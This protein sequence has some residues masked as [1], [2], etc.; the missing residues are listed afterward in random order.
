MLLAGAAFSGLVMADCGSRT[1]KGGIQW[2]A[3]RGVS[4][5][6]KES[7]NNWYNVYRSNQVVGDG[8]DFEELSSLKVK[9]IRLDSYKTCTH[10][11]YCYSNFDL[12]NE[13]Y[14]YCIIKD[15]NNNNKQLWS[16]KKKLALEG[17]GSCSDGYSYPRWYDTV[18]W[19]ITH[20]NN[21]G[22]KAGRY[23][24][25]F[26]FLL[27]G[28]G[29]SG[30]SCS[31]SQ[32]YGKKDD[33]NNF[34]AYFVI[35]GMSGANSLS[36]ETVNKDG[37]PTQ[38][39][40]AYKFYAY[41][42]TS[43]T[44]TISSDAGS[45][46]SLSKASRTT[47]S[48][49]SI[50]ATTYASSLTVYYSAASEG[51]HTATLTISG[52]DKLGNPQSI[53][54]ALNGSTSD[55]YTTKVL[56]EKDAVVEVGP[57]ATLYG[58][59]KHTGCQTDIKTYGFYYKKKTGGAIPTEEEIKAGSHVDITGPALTVNNC[60]FS[61]KILSGLEANSDY[62]YLAYVK[63]DG[64]VTTYSPYSSVGH[65][66][67]A[68]ACKLPKGDVINYYVD[69]SLEED[70]P[71]ELRFKSIDN[72][73]D[74]LRS[75]TSS[76]YDWWD[77]T[78]KTLKVNVILNIYDGNYGTSGLLIDLKNIN[79][80]SAAS[81]PATK[82]LTVQGV[83]GKPTLYGLDLS[84]SR[85]ITVK[86]VRIERSTSG[87]GLT[88]SCVI[89]GYPDPMNS[90]SV[91]DLPE[92]NLEFIDTDIDATAFTCIHG[93]GVNGLYM[94]NCNLKANRTGD[95]EDNDR[96]WGASI[97][98]MNCK[99]ISLL[100]NNFRGSHANNIFFQNSRNALIMNNVFWNDNEITYSASANVDSPSFIR[101]VNFGANDT[102]HDITN[103]GIYY[104]TFYLAESSA[105]NE[106]LKKFDYLI[107]SGPAQIKD[108]GNNFYSARYIVSSIHFQYNN[109]YSYSTRI[110]GKSSDPFHSLDVDLYFKNNN[111]WA[112]NDDADYSF[113][114][115]EKKNVDMSLG[116]PM[117]CV[118][119]PYNP[120]D[121]IIKG[122]LL[123]YGQ[124]ITSDVSG[125][126]AEAVYDDRPHLGARPASGSGW[127]YGAYQQTLP[128]DTPIE[129]IV[130]NGA[131]NTDW[132]NRNN[133][134]KAD[135]TSVNC[136]DKLSENLKVLIPEPEN[137][138]YRPKSEEKITNY[139]TIQA[140]SA[141]STEEEV[142]AGLGTE[143]TP[144]EYA[145]SIELEYGALL[146]GIENLRDPADKSNY[147]YFEATNHNVVPKKTWRLVGTVMRPFADES[148]LPGDSATTLMKADNY[149]KNFEPHVYM[150]QMNS[151]ASGFNMD[152][153]FT[154][155]NTLVPSDECFAVF[156]ANQYGPRKLIAE[157]YYGAD[158]AYLGE[159]A[160][161]F[162]FRGH[163]A[164]DYRTG[165]PSYTFSVK[166]KW[167]YVNNSY[168][169]NL[170]VSEF[171]T[172]N[173]VVKL[174]NGTSF[175]DYNPLSEEEIRPQC[176]FI[177]KNT[178]ASPVVIALDGDS[179]TTNS[180]KYKGANA[181]TGLSLTAVNTA[182]DKGSSIGA[183]QDYKNIT[184]MENS[185]DNEVCELY[186]NGRDDRYSTISFQNADTVIS[187]GI[188]NKLVN[189]YMSV[190][191]TLENYQGLESV[192]LEDRGVEPVVR[193]DL[194]DGE[195]PYIQRLQPGYIDGRFF[196]II[197]SGTE[198]DQPTSVEEVESANADSQ[199]S[200]TSDEGIVTV[201]SSQNVLLTGAYITDMSGRTSYVE[202]KNAHYN[203][204]NIVGSAG[205]YIVN[206]IGDTMSKSEK[207]IVK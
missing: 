18:E 108:D 58:Y 124:R 70:D 29:C 52:N 106:N 81:I 73:L 28:K 36:I 173:T 32:I 107:F 74:D 144:T 170:K 96:N 188:H 13:T 67:T 146:L 179:Y 120:D 195:Q 39:S 191:F 101:L 57:K 197:G 174:F 189:K 183:I 119:A 105:A 156:A 66:R 98:F 150:Q 61:G 133:W 185:S 72:A 112:E 100:R 102:D 40:A 141:I 2:E 8:H 1:C 79:K 166:D 71:C 10:D 200:I 31:T 47:S 60:S 75:H 167:Y 165:K 5:H 113:G 99:N 135:G 190:R 155:R 16:G 25:E 139:P 68:G 111:F 161:E 202:F 198:E 42:L 171:S 177:V 140:W 56:V 176:G 46:F 122:D 12:C 115:A 26:Y 27:Q 88:E 35:P 180:T 85:N 4:F 7:N 41:G 104:N 125:M 95:V 116:G 77:A 114:G 175:N 3:S 23:L 121:L 69:S 78:N 130:W 65:F 109:C 160:E 33:N 136:V 83:D 194:L 142:R 90:R 193:Y 205:V 53:T 37:S 63:T 80:T 127:T 43:C 50:N 199:I 145:H 110:P 201:S 206:A 137:D 14:F 6:I 182:V 48:S 89:I 76:D 59:L 203:R 159:Q 134:V 22:S 187:L 186:V 97:K 192:I 181:M 17:W 157:M 24:A 204:F 38:G 147:R 172:A 49:P 164:D 143:T 82:R 62:Y 91:G 93:N 152:L 126:G 15:R 45:N 207:V 153:P 11:D 94:T 132:D 9:D 103:V 149:F 169:A 51:D 30:S 148:K 129:F 196:L 163:F 158:K 128:S 54:V 84:Y 131:H 117:V 34:K 138:R 178:S 92:F 151:D 64:G 162:T 154:D 118:N 86:N 168:P 21:F 20:S 44:A 184:K 87:T 55:S 123:N 19:E